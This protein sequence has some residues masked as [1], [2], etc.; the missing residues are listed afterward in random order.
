ML[1]NLFL[2]H[3][4]GDQTAPFQFQSTRHYSRRYLFYTIRYTNAESTLESH[5]AI[6]MTGI[7]GK[8]WEKQTNLNRIE[9]LIDRIESSSTQQFAVY[10]PTSL[11]HNSQF[12]SDTMALCH[13]VQQNEGLGVLLQR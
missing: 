2:T 1:V 6:I 3:N 10:K 4:C 12:Q 13:I 11:P 8:T 9:T 7:V 5:I